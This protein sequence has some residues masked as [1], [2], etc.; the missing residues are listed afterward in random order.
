MLD[1]HLKLK[2]RALT[3]AEQEFCKSNEDSL[4]LYNTCLQKMQYTPYYL[5][6]VI[7]TKNHV[8]SL[9]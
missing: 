3:N 7:L 2:F 1:V 6:E 5:I 4:N 9:L 8:S